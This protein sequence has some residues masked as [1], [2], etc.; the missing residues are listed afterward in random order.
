[1]VGETR[2]IFGEPNLLISA[3]TVRV[4]V[5]VGHGESI[6]AEFIEPMHADRAIGILSDKNMR[7]GSCAST[8]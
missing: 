4:P 8:V 5:L 3:T 1:M 2:K 6:N 7:R